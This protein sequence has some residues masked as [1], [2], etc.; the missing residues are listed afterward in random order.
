MGIGLIEIDEL[1]EVGMWRQQAE[2]V[3]AQ[4]PRL[5]SELFVRT[6]IRELIAWQVNDL[7]GET[8]RRLYESRIAGIPVVRSHAA[9]LVTF[10]AEMLAYKAA[11]ENFL[12]QRVYRHARVLRMAA[13]GRRCLQA[14]FHEMVRVPELLPIGHL[15]RWEQAPTHVVRPERPA[16]SQPV[17]REPRLER[18]VADYLAGMTDR[19]ARQEYLRLFHPDGDS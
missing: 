3:R 9:P 18:V 6:V 8:E 11:L 2:R 10:S 16:L 5:R 15:W 12:R 17:V 7:I 14:L 1:E 4:F 19:F 13:K